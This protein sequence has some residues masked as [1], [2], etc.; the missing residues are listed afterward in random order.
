MAPAQSRI[1]AG[2]FFAP[3]GAGRVDARA[4]FVD[5]DIGDAVVLQFVR[6]QVGQHFLRFTAGCP[7]AERRRGNVV[8]LDQLGEFRAGFGLLLR[9]ADQMDH[10]MIQQVAEF[11]EHR[12]LA[13]AFE[14]WIDGQ[15]APPSHG[16]LQQQVPQVLREH[17]DGMHLRVFRQL[18]ANL[19]L[20]ARQHQPRQRIVRAA[21]EKFR[22]GM[23]RRHE[24]FIGCLLQFVGV[25]V[26]PHAEHLRF[27]AAVDRQHAMRG[28]LAELLLILEIIAE[29][30]PLLFGDLRL[31]ADELP[32]P[33]D[34][35]PQPLAEF[36]PF[37]EILRQDMPDPEQCI[38]RRRHLVIGI[39]E[40]LRATVE[41][42][43]RD[44]AAENLLGQRL[45][46]PLAR[47]GCQRLLLRLE[48]HVKI[49]QPFR[50]IGGF[51]RS[52][53][54]GCQLPLPVDRSQNCLLPLG[55][56][57]EAGNA[58]L[59]LADL[60]FVQS[61]G[62]ILAIAGNEGNRIPRI[63][64]AHHVLDAFQGKGQC[65]GDGVQVD[66]GR[67]THAQRITIDSEL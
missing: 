2:K 46:F 26:D 52:G 56:L 39:D 12:Q 57:A 15:H 34:D 63:Q 21:A 28:N 23:V 3:D 30:L 13:T 19:A 54:F 16:R 66:G 49:F 61:P 18:A 25:G 40:I 4:G 45:K 48:R 50:A 33:L 51:D 8:R 59:N 31:D 35:S 58:G 32:G 6:H 36:G 62:L 10:G 41:I 60:F 37:A 14:T 55:Q 47:D 1:I 9:L 11:V 27:F 53:E 38:G 64:Q 67:E 42:G 43:R 17:A 29:L 20:E 7:V 24:Q 65:V 22:M 44:R 5:D